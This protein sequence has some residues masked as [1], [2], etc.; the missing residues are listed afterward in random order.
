MTVVCSENGAIFA[1]V[2]MLKELIANYPDKTPVLVNH[3]PGMFV[4]EMECGYINL[5]SMQNPWDYPE[6]DTPATGELYMDF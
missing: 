1:D 6:Y 2:G 5:D 3:V 4:P